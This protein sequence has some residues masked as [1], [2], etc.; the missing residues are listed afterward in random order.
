MILGEVQMQAIPDRMPSKQCWMLFKVANLDR[1]QALQRGLLYMNSVDYFAKLNGETGAALRRDTLEN[2]YLKL[3]SGARDGVVTELALRIDG[4]DEIVLNPEAI[5][6]LHLPRPENVMVYCLGSVSAGPDGQVWGL[7]NGMLQFSERFREF[8]TH[9]LRITNHAEFS[10]RLSQVI[11][12]HPHLYNS[13][14]FEGGYGQVDYLDFSDYSGAVGLF[15]KPIEYAWQREYRLCFGAEP[16]ALNGRGALE[17]NIGD[18]SDIT[19]I[20]T[21]ESFTSNP[22]TLIKRSY[23]II[24]GKPV[25]VFS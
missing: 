6:T 24:D 19:Q 9:V 7:D 17:L 21:V 20:T 11:A 12:D 2:V 10:R 5:M 18:L 14:F 4:H 16:E 8:G 23:K 1:L 15:R 22:I 3:S 13:P 25:Q